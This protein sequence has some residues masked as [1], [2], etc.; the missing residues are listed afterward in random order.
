M[1]IRMVY[2]IGMRL[3]ISLLLGISLNGCDMT[4]SRSVK[5]EIDG[6]ILRSVGVIKSRK[7]LDLSTLETNSSETS[8][9]AKIFGLEYLATDGGYRSSTAI[10]YDVE[11]LDGGLLTVYSESWRYQVDDCVNIIIDID[12]PKNQPEFYLN[13]NDC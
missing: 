8:S 12:N 10:R 7:I 11:L 1:L 4:A 6:G 3:L 9:E 13:K 5:T 2:G